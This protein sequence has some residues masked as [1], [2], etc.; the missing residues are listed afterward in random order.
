M[1]RHQKVWSSVVRL[2]L[3][4]FSL[5]LGAAIAAFVL[6]GITSNVLG[7]D[8][9][10]NISLLITTI[11]LANLLNSMVGGVAML[12]A[13][14]KAI[15]KQDLLQK[16]VISYFWAI[17]VNIVA[18]FLFSIF[19]IV[20]SKLFLWTVILGILFSFT[21]INSLFV[22]H[23][24]KINSYMSINFWQNVIS[25]GTF[26]IILNFIPQ[27]IGNAFNISL[28]VA[29]TICFVFT[30]KSVE[31]SY[32]YLESG[33]GYPNRWNTISSIISSG[34]SAQTGNILLFLV[35]RIHFYLIGIYFGARALGVYSVSI[36]LME[37]LWMI[38][39]SIAIV[40]FS[41][42]V[43]NGL[44]D[45]TEKYVLTCVKVSFSLTAIALVVVLLI[46]IN[47]YN[48][49]FGDGFDGIKNIILTV[50]A[51]SLATSVTT[52]FHHYFTAAQE[53]RVVLRIS[54]ISFFI[55]LI[56]GGLFIPSGGGLFAAGLTSSVANVVM[57]L[58][59][60]YYFC[61]RTQ[62]RPS[63]LLISTEDIRQLAAMARSFK[64]SNAHD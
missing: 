41:R 52:I 62:S 4:G 28:L 60:V 8:G 48:I 30:S 64:R 57:M 49:I 3:S 21:S 7:P 54:V 19:F 5:K 34:F 18:A 59:Y 51:G 6:V 38:S 56:G 22:M 9:R 53:Y 17:I 2:V 26:C 42:I 33:N 46:P 1:T 10:G 13:I 63:A 47:V 36:S 11:M 58:G 29:Y 25:L 43:K 23:L 55:S 35:Y 16:I 24:N 44:D 61:Q 50:A 37:A 20:D 27:Y 15:S 32:R 14:K 39:G 31:E 40:M 12:P 45:D